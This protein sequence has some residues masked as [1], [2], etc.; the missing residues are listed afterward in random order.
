LGKKHALVPLKLRLALEANA[1]HVAG[2]DATR[3]PV[4]ALPA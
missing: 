3:V 4:R 2:A 1:D